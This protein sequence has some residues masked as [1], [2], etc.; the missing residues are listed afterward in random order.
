MLENVVYD[1]ET[2][3]VEYADG[4]IREN[5]RGPYPIE[6]VTNAHIPCVAGHPRDVIFFACDAFGVLPR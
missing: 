1:D 4:S 2:N 6:H 5:T 3:A